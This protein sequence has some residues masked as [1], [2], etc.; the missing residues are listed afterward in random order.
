VYKDP[1]L[2]TYELKST[3]R[4]DRRLSAADLAT[5]RQAI[6]REAMELVLKS[7]TTARLSEDLDVASGGAGLGDGCHTCS[8]GSAEGLAEIRD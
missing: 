3:I 1:L 2:A 8:D 4:L 7:K 5:N 6:E